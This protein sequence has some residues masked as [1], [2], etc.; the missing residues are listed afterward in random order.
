MRF[1]LLLSVV[2]LLAAPAG[3]ARHESAGLSVE[4]PRGWS[5]VRKPLSPC[6]N[7]VQRLALVGHGALVQIVETLDYAYVHR[8]PARPK[9]FALRGPAQYQACCPPRRAKGWFLHF[10]DG[11]RGFYAY[12]YLGARGTRTELL[13]ILDSLVVRPRPRS[14]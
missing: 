11:N 10:R 7:P 14:A 1:A 2:L 4:M 13:R 12:V 3:A 8:F 5:V 6:T 9:R